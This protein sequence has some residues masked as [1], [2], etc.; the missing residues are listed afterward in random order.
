MRAALAKAS[1][2]KRTGARA[3]RCVWQYERDEVACVAVL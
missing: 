2:V 3:E 1:E